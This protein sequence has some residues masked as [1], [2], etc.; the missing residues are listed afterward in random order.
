MKSVVRD[1]KDKVGKLSDTST[2]FYEYVTVLDDKLVKR[3]KQRKGML[4]MNYW[5]K[6]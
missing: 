6:Q 4:F 5:C 1:L 2:T 3:Q